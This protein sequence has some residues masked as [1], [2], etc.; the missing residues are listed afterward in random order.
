M[1][2]LQATRPDALPASN[3]AR[4]F[5]CKQQPDALPASNNTCSQLVVTVLGSLLLAVHMLLK[6]GTT[7][8]A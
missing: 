3:T 4:C 5:A 8:L 1:L 7:N 2:C 6:F